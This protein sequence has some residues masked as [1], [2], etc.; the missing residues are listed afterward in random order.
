MNKI[1]LKKTTVIGLLLFASNLFSAVAES[2]YSYQKM[3][4]KNALLYVQGL[5]DAYST[6][7]ILKQNGLENCHKGSSDTELKAIFDQ[8]L[9]NHQNQAGNSAGSLLL[10]SLKE[11][12]TKATHSKQSEKSS[13]TVKSPAVEE[14]MADYLLRMQNKGVPNKPSGKTASGIRRDRK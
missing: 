1:N 5:Y 8:W 14:S 9:K 10:H 3:S 2:G 13:Q 11:S 4:E 7:G 12:C 6:M